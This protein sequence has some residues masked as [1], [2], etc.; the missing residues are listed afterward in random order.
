MLQKGFVVSRGEAR[1]RPKHT[2]RLDVRLTLRVFLTRAE[3][4]PIMGRYQTAGA[5]EVV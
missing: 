2:L 4:I 1:C 5:E 3:M